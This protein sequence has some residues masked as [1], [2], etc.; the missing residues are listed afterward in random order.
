MPINLKN[1]SI[2]RGWLHHASVLVRQE[3]T[4]Q[5]IVHLV[6][7][8]VIRVVYFYTA[9]NS[10]SIQC[11]HAKSTD[12]SNIPFSTCDS[13]SVAALPASALMLACADCSASLAAGTTLSMT[14]SFRPFT[15][16]SA[17]ALIFCWISV[18][19]SPTVI[20][21][22]CCFMPARTP[23]RLFSL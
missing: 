23:S 13:L 2:F 4:D 8:L 18:T 12:P 22:M 21:L 1:V 20:E 10:V 6:D 9:V 3:I 5:L 11:N 15:I 14:V 16:S 7:Y 17:A 19:D